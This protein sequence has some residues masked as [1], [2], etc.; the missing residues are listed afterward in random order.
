MYSTNFSGSNANQNEAHVAFNLPFLAR[1]IK[2]TP[3]TNEEAFALFADTLAKAQGKP[4]QVI[5]TPGVDAMGNAYFYLGLRIE[6]QEM[7][8]KLSV[9]E[10]ITALVLAYMC[11]A[12]QLPAVES[13]IPMKVA[14]ENKLAWYHELET[15]L[16]GLKA[17][18]KER[19]EITPTVT[20]L[21]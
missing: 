15:K 17:V 1:Q 3:R 14:D 12:E 9:N 21:R 18:R 5:A 10:A 11:G 7:D 13:L 2:L 20:T 8:L 19:L 6:H 4:L 16:M